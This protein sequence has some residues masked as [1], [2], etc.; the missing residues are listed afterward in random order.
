MLWKKITS[1]FSLKEK[2]GGKEV[3]LFRRYNQRQNL[4]TVDSYFS[5]GKD[6]DLKKEKK[7]SYIMVSKNTVRLWR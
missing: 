6:S 1:G 3:K 4:N 2:I 7:I 5:H